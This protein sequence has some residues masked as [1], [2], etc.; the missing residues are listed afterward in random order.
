MGV[1]A[2][3]CAHSYSHKAA[4]PPL[5]AAQLVQV[6]TVNPCA[7]AL[8]PPSCPPCDGVCCSGA[9]R[10]LHRY[11]CAQQGCHLEADDR[12][13]HRRRGTHADGERP[14]RALSAHLPTRVQHLRQ[15]ADR[16][17]GGQAHCYSRQGESGLM[18]V[19]L[20]Q[21]RAYHRR[22]LQPPPLVAVRLRDADRTEA[23]QAGTQGTTREIHG[24]G[25]PVEPHQLRIQAYLLA[26]HRRRQG[27]MV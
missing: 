2:H 7:V 13:D 9:A 18:L 8:L 16:Q 12:K 21:H 1:A 26:L 19:H 11:E 25:K 22:E 10:I 17:A 20:T 4:L 6:G 14:C 27:R 5:R 3:G 24:R 23:D 15:Y